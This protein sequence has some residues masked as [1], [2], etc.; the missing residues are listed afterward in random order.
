MNA[1]YYRFVYRRLMRFT[2]HFGWHRA[3][4][5]G[6]LQPGGG[7]VRLCDWCGFS[8]ALRSALQAFGEEAGMV[9]HNCEH[10]WVFHEAIEVAGNDDWAL[11]EFGAC[12]VLGCSCKG[13]P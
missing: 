9:K 4:L 7:Y 13:R 10:S 2:H 11:T 6:P 8:Q 1:L 3:R 5:L 12:A